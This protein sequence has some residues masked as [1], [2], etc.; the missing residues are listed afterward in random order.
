M[1]VRGD[2]PHKT[3]KELMEFARNNSGK[4]S[5]GI[6]GVGTAVEIFTRAMLRHT[7][8]DATVVPFKGDA[9]LNT[10]LLGGQIVAGSYSA[11]GFVPQ[12]Q[13]GK[14]RLLA[15]FQGDRF[16]VAPDVPT[17]EEMRYGLT[18]T[19]I[20]ILFGPKG[21]PPAVAKRLIADLGKALKSKTY[22]DIASKNE[23]YEKK[24][25]AGDALHA[26]LLKDRATNRVMVEKLGLKKQ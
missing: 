5:V 23:L 3:L 8:A 10:A 14:M 6:P 9:D 25:L 19:T 24:V 12:I 22:V 20:Q 17:L 26:Y 21:L 13:A 18:S 2:S 11:G 7:N 1:V 15:S 16:S 4:V